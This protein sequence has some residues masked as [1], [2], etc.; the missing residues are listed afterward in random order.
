MPIPNKASQ[1]PV[2]PSPKASA[3]SPVAPS[4]APPGKPGKPGG[5]P[6]APAVPATPS[7]A[8]ATPTLVTSADL[9]GVL[10]RIDALTG[11]IDALASTI[12][13]ARKAR[14]AKAANTITIEEALEGNTFPENS[15]DWRAP[16]HGGTFPLYALDRAQALKGHLVP[17]TSQ[18]V[19]DCFVVRP[20]KRLDA[21]NGPDADHRSWLAVYWRAADVD[22]DGTPT[23]YFGPPAYLD[24]DEL[25]AFWPS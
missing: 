8:A 14:A 7:K 20:S 6:A 25:G 23:A 17:D 5:A 13:A 19:Q 3:A 21:E 1:K 24:A 15:D 4:K 11:K 2:T 16:Y 18:I 10:V 9:A 22:A 12:E